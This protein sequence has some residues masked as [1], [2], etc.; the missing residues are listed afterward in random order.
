MCLHV[1]PDML[2]RSAIYRCPDMCSNICRPCVVPCVVTLGFLEPSGFTLASHHLEHTITELIDRL[3]VLT[4]D[5][6]LGVSKPAVVTRIR[7]EN[8]KD[9]R[10]HLHLLCR[11]SISCSAAAWTIAPPWYRK[12]DTPY[13]TTFTQNLHRKVEVP[14]SRLSLIWKYYDQFII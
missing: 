3:T 10:R 7:R 5:E 6:L 8:W 11:S 9:A 2:F 13:L 1:F 14:G 4:P 12:Q